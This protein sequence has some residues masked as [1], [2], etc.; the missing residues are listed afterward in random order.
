MYLTPSQYSIYNSLTSPRCAA[1]RDAQPENPGLRRRRTQ[2]HG[3]SAVCKSLNRDRLITRALLAPPLASMA[4]PLPSVMT[5]AVVAVIVVVL[6]TQLLSLF[7]PSFNS[8]IFGIFL[9]L[10]L[11]LLSLSLL[12]QHCPHSSAAH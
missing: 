11:L 9:L 3:H 7:F 4:H 1:H 12:Q 8:I 5:G 6:N 10:L 2:V